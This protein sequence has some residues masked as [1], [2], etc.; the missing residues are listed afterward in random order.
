MTDRNAEEKRSWSDPP[1]GPSP[2]CGPSSSAAE[3]A[4]SS[5][6]GS[7]CCAPATESRAGSECCGPAMGSKCPIKLLL[8]LLVMGAAVAVA[9]HAIV[10][11]SGSATEGSAAPS[12]NLD[13]GSSPGGAAQGESSCRGAREAF[14]ATLESIEALKE[15]AADKEAVFVLLSGEDEQHTQAVRK[16]VEAAVVKI[17]S[18]GHRVGSLTLGKH[19]DGYTMLVKQFS[20]TS[21]PS[22]LALGDGCEAKVVAGGI[23][24]AK[25][26]Q[27]FVIASAPPSACG[28]S[29][30]DSAN[31]R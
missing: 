11:K 21:F 26:L 3:G 16:Q 19:S 18:Q 25:L 23:T 29:G 9:V 28:S 22:V 30:C 20:I 24:E 13:T 5:G 10:K 27:A 15:V 17:E 4:A 7:D 6:R 8:F 2:C 12:G 1:E 14:R 31:C